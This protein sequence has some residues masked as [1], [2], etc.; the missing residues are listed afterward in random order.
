MGRCAAETPLPLGS[1]DSQPRRSQP[2]ERTLRQASLLAALWALGYGFYRWYY[3]FGGTVG[4]LGI[5]A[6]HEDWRRINAVAGVLLWVA[7]LLPLVLMRAWRTRGVYPLLL[8]LSGIVTVGCISH[9]LIDIVLRV[10]SL[11]GSLTIHY[12]FWQTIDHRRADLQDLFF[13]E[14]WFLVEGLLWAAIAWSGALH[15]APRWRRWW[16]VGVLITTAASTAV[17]I[18]SGFGVVGAWIIG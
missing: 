4:I 3:A 5:P 9:A 13:N 10:A 15:G 6:S 17:G 1:D 16:I 14:P 18:L 8:V 7:A 2:C 12:P 11:N